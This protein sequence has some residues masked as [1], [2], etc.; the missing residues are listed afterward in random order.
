MASSE[1]ED[2][3]T[4]PF[5]A[6]ILEFLVKNH[7]SRD[8]AVRYRCCQLINKIL[9]CMGEDAMIGTLNLFSPLERNKMF[10]KFEL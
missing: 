2:D 1:M 10:V 7:N 9:N 4:E 5:L 6:Q 3:V 8:K